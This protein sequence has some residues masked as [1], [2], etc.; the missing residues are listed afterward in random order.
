ML[1]VSDVSERHKGYVMIT[2]TA[3]GVTERVSVEDVLAIS[4]KL[5][6]RGIT[7]QG[8]FYPVMPVGVAKDSA[9]YTGELLCTF[10]KQFL[11]YKVI[12]TFT[13]CNHVMY[14]L[15]SIPTENGVK[16]CVMY[17][18]NGRFHGKPFLQDCFAD[19]RYDDNYS[20][21]LF[22]EK[23]FDIICTKT[24]DDNFIKDFFQNNCHRYT[25][26]E[27]DKDYYICI[28]GG[29]Y[30]AEYLK[31]KKY[32]AQ[33]SR[34][35]NPYFSDM[36]YGGNVQLFEDI[37]MYRTRTGKGNMI[38]VDT[39]GVKYYK[40][41]LCYTLHKINSLDKRE[42]YMERITED[43]YDYRKNYSARYLIHNLHE[44]D[45]NKDSLSLPLSTKNVIS[46][47]V[48]LTEQLVLNPLANND[49]DF[50]AF[51]SLF[52]DSNLKDKDTIHETLK[53]L[54]EYGIITEEVYNNAEEMLSR[55][56]ELTEGGIVFIVD[57][58]K[59][60]M[61]R[62]DALS[63]IGRANCTNSKIMKKHLALLKLLASPYTIEPVENKV[64]VKDIKGTTT[65]LDLRALEGIIGCSIVMNKAN[66][67][68]NHEHRMSI[69]VTKQQGMT[70]IAYTNNLEVIL[71][72]S[73]REVISYCEDISSMWEDHIRVVTKIISNTTDRV[74]AEW[75]GYNL[76]NDYALNIVIFTNKELIPYYLRGALVGL[77]NSLSNT[78]DFEHLYTTFAKIDNDPILRE[79]IKINCQKLYN[80]FREYT[81]YF[82][83]IEGISSDIIQNLLYF[84]YQVYFHTAKRYSKYYEDAY[85]DIY[86]EDRLNEGFG[87]TM[88]TLMKDS[89]LLKSTYDLIEN[90]IVEKDGMFK[91]CWL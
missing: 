35:N 83:S 25:S 11:T 70:D 59:I 22:K 30:L 88:K 49:S 73:C 14:L 28:Y 23:H 41:H 24:K 17:N 74:T 29:Y 31:S 67:T 86:F 42:E 20:K 91:C 36:K 16:Y 68:I 81:E 72:D 45:E 1:Y 82:D 80:L 32:K 37:P 61:F 6:I 57:P 56:T 51:H 44:L 43:F 18:A 4:V 87:D 84:C 13:L 47:E 40:E 8:E 15:V 9:V 48:L 71:P 89:K 33:R 65:T 69:R 46:G 10:D 34:E 58:Y 38:L 63:D 78:V 64:R 5:N 62:L 19:T 53:D 12:D 66:A 76:G 75:L 52:K 27:P 60:N 3:D 85:I 90:R 79:C 54:L 77:Y 26:Y 55:T 7:E 2:D 50:M 39:Q 21:N